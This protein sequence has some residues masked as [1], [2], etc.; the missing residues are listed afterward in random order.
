[1]IGR[2]PQADQW[3]ELRNKGEAISEIGQFGMSPNTVSRHT[4]ISDDELQR[5]IE[6]A[7]LKLESEGRQITNIGIWRETSQHIPYAT[8]ARILRELGYRGNHGKRRSTVWTKRCAG[9]E[10]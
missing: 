6:Q 7:V 2:S 5:W 8:M 3:Q 9:E 10:L 1:M 4:A